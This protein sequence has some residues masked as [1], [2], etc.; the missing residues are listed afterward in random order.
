MVKAELL[1]SVHDNLRAD[2]GNFSRASVPCEDYINYSMNEMR[3]D[4][5][6]VGY[7]AEISHCLMSQTQL[8]GAPKEFLLKDQ[9]RFH[10]STCASP[11]HSGCVV[12]T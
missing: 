6:F 7:N 1:H 12:F 9:S 2:F 3:F 5:S 10:L 11:V 8:T 4:K